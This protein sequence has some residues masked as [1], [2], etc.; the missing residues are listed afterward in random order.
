MPR[1]THA[2]PQ[3][4]NPSRD[5]VPLSEVFTS[6]VRICF[7]QIRFCINFARILLR[8]RYDFD[9]DFVKIFDS[10]NLAFHGFSEESKSENF[11]GSDH[12]QIRLF[13]AL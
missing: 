2:C 1:S 11:V 12:L 5:P 9:D 3:K 7:F 10:C 8:N 6:V 4:S 13:N